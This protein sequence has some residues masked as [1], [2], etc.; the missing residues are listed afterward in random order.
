MKN[1]I[2]DNLSLIISISIAITFFASLF[3]GFLTIENDLSVYPGFN[4]EG[5][6]CTAWDS[7]SRK[8]N[9][10]PWIC[11]MLLSVITTPLGAVSVKLACAKNQKLKNMIWRS[12]HSF[13]R[14]YA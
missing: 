10:L 1:L 13:F 11:F 8:M 5:R 4:K 2:L 9:W 12:E 6:G 14:Q 3:F 7:Y